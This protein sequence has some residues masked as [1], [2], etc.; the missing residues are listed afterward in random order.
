MMSRGPELSKAPSLG[1]LL[2]ADH[3]M[4]GESTGL[5]GGGEPDRDSE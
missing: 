1:G 5:A 2:A 3:T 4:S